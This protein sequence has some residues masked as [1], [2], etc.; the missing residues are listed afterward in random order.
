MTSHKASAKVRT[1]KTNRKDQYGEP[2]P[3]DLVVLS[4]ENPKDFIADGLKAVD[5]ADWYEANGII[6]VPWHQTEIFETA[7]EDAGLDLDDPTVEILKIDAV[8]HRYNEVD[9]F[10]HA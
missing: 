2:I 10:Y 5:K 7:P 1:M 8:L 9:G 4:G 6:L 3:N